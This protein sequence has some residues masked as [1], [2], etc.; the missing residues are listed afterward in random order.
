MDTPAHPQP[1]S[2]APGSAAR[3]T[4]LQ[5]AKR[6]GVSRATASLVIRDAAGPSARSRERVLQAAA[7]LGYRP[8]RNAQLLR[9]RQSRLLG[10]L[11][12]AQDPF[13][14]DI[15]ENIYASAEERGY[16]VVLSSVFATRSEERAFEALA[17]SR[18][19]A[20]IALGPDQAC[21]TDFGSHLPI[22][23]IGRPSDETSF[24]AVFTDDEHGIGLAVDHLVALG[25]RA[26]VHIDGGHAPGAAE[27][28]A[29]YQRA[30]KSHEL[31]DHTRILPGDYTE[32]SGAVAAQQLLSEDTLPTAV[33]AGNDQ[34]AAGLIDELR[35]AGVEIPAQISIVGYDDSRLARLAHINLTTVRQ[36]V[37]QL[38]RLSVDAAIDRLEET[39]NRQSPRTFKL[40]PHLVT[41][42]STGPARSA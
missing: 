37:E 16:D 36:D 34:C 21:S 20:V 40:I 30:M 33:I 29:G 42:G 23:E 19:Q 38:A 22:V 1:S 10:V 11:F 31:Q 39:E 4:L 25:H 14:A 41:R 3:P 32:L 26:I 6:A 7:E 35:S 24:D 27:R 9:Q 15:I 13:H 17:A 8:D 2:A 12:R 28:R 5:V 18:C